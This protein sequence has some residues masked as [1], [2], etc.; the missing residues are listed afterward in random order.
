MRTLDRYILKQIISPF[1]YCIAIFTFLYIVID[2]FENLDEI[3]KEHIAL[4]TLGRYYLN[5]IPLMFIQTSSIAMLV[6]TTYVLVNLNRHNE[7]TAMRTAG[8]S[9]LRISTPFLIMAFM[10]SVLCF[11]VSD[12]VVPRTSVITSS[13]KQEEM[14]RGPRKATKLSNVTLY[15]TQNRLI[16]VKSY[17]IEN[18]SLNDIIILEQDKNRIIQSKIIARQAKWKGS[19]W[20]FYDVTVYK[21]DREGR[22]KETPLNYE[23]KFLGIREKPE[24]FQKSQTDPMLMS[25]REL[26]NYIN[27]FRGIGEQT[28]RRLLVDLY[29]KVSFSFTSFI[30]VLI[31]IPTVLVIKAKR[32]LLLVLGLSMAIGFIYYAAMALSAGLGKAGFIPPLLSA[33]LANIIFGTA[34]IVI[35][36]RL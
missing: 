36:R 20:K 2:L 33:W 21:L 10:V 11:L 34:G 9:I 31:G 27:K 32:G 7:I 35:L 29:C 3:L 16:Y 15:G 26:K 22:I 24:D 14:K 13:I 19:E 6:S 8:I 18:E 30:I 1:L 23:E 5:F 28:V 17:D 25:Y 12:K 4:S